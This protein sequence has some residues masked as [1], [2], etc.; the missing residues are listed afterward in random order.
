M[1]LDTLDNAARYSSSIPGLSEA[2]AFVAK[3]ASLA[4]GRHALSGENYALIQEYE[5][6][7]VAELAWEAHRNY[8][9][10]QIMLAGAESMGWAAGMV[11]A[12]PYDEA[13]DAILAPKATGASELAMTPGLFV[14]FVPGEAHRPRARLGEAMKVRKLVVKLRMK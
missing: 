14:L 5:T 8:A 3:A 12:A 1:I 9:D 7:D 10:V 2:L 4:P 6:L 13:K 11:E